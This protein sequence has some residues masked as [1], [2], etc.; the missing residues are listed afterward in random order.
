MQININPKKELFKWGPIEFKLVY[1]SFFI[2]TILVR[3]EDFYPWHWPP[4][5]AIIQQGKLTFINGCLELQKA[6]LKYF[7][8][9]FLNLNNYKI[10]WQKWEDW[11]KEYEKMAQE[12]EQIKWQNISDK[13][14]SSLLKKFYNFN[15]RFWLIVHVPE[16]ANWG[17]EYLL[18]NKLKN[19]FP[20]KFE[21]YLEILSAPIKFSFFQQEELD[22]L[23][24][25]SIKNKKE[26]QKKLKQHAKEY[27]WLLNSYGGNR[28][29]KVD[30]FADKLKELLQ[31]K[32][33]KQKIKEI[34]DNVK[35]NKTRKD[36]L[37]KEL[38]LSKDLVLTAKQL[39]QSIWWQDLRKG[40]IWQM[41]Y[42]WD[43]F[44]REISKRTDWKFD[45]L[46]LCY[47]YEILSIVKNE[48]KIN[49]KEINKRK[50]YYAFYAEKGKFNDFI[51]VQ[52][53]KKLISTYL[54]TATGNIKELKGLVVS[55]GRATITRGRVKIISNP[56]K[57]SCK[58]EKVDILVAGM[59]SPEFIIVMKKAKAIITDHGG[60]TSHAAIVSR[61]LGVPCIVGTKIATQVLKDG[62]LVEVDADQGVI[63]IIK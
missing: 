42:F 14:L 16:I 47:G 23:F 46:Q 55:R 59:T 53:I 49:K 29:L 18:T 54:K 35:K 12:L 24:L 3:V 51:Q 52:P 4:A 36:K 5:L 7:R 48:N 10:H 15:I 44:L 9:Y 27:R 58:M 61:E 57:E 22:L 1:G 21:K 60:M 31:E 50:K 11:I 41:N 17:G 63:K 45:E 19:L 26:F 56:F 32:S 6:G 43:K 33:A 30:Y 40:Y 34:K 62:D 39:S 20:D 37:I 38:K 8:K 13:E 25:D 28:I 2:E